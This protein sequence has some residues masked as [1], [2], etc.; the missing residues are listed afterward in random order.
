MRRKEGG[1]HRGKSTNKSPF[2]L[3]NPPLPLLLRLF[4]L[5]PADVEARAFTWA[6]S[7]RCSVS[8]SAR[9][10]MLQPEPEDGE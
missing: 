9:A 10:V 1:R 3:R 8:L 7:A 2:A 4:V 6:V 5:P